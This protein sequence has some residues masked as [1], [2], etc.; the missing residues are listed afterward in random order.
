MQKSARLLN[1][2]VIIEISDC[3]IINLSPFYWNPF[4]FHIGQVVAVI[5]IWCSLVSLVSSFFF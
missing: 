3:T 1:H 4:L 5:Y 2:Q